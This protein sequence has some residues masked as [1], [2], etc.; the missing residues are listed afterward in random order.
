MDM[1]M[2]RQT[3]NHRRR[4]GLLGR[5]G[6]S[7]TEFIIV[8]PTILLLTLGSL[9]MGLIYWARATVNL[10][11]FQAARAGALDHS[12]ID[13]M[14]E[15]FYKSM[16]PQYA[17]KADAGSIIKAYKRVEKEGKDGYIKVER[18]SPSAKEFSA[19][20]VKTK[21]GTP[22]PN[23][24]LMYRSTKPSGGSTMSIQ[25]ANLLKVKVTYGYKLVV[26]LMK[27]IIIKILKTGMMPR[28]YGKDE[29]VKAAETDP[30]LL[31]LYADDRIPIVSYATV[32]M[33]TS[34]MNM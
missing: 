10:A 6:Q 4:G 21:A 16:A 28:Q 24:N 22:I 29:K 27:T 13:S 9:Q 7:M 30:F 11:T 18:I 34:P 14:K 23:D 5:A 2:G 20:G 32:R 33:Q 19:Y 26:P 3:M 1:P 17:F 12:K 15:E 8:W 31:S 25:D